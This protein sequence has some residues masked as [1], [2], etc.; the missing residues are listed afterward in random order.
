MDIY[1]F[2]K[3]FTCVLNLKE[4]EGEKTTENNKSYKRYLYRAIRYFVNPNYTRLFQAK[5]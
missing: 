4:G 3:N 2:N 5:I 1:I